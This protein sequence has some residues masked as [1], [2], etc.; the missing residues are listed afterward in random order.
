[1]SED[2]QDAAQEAIAASRLERDRTLGAI[3]SLET[4]LGQAADISTWLD[5]VESDLGLLEDAMVE[6]QRDLNRPDALLALIASRH[7][8]RF[9]PRIRSL[10]E[11]YDDIIRQVASLRRQLA[12]PG[13]SHPNAEDLRHRAGWVIRALHHCR[14]RQADLVYDALRLDIGERPS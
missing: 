7:P 10:R 9:G 5:R 8:R 13:E 11:Q 6:E 2:Q 12:N 1:M 3:H 4:S 14:G